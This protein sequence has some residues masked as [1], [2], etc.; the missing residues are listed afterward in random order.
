M[1]T[2]LG[3]DIGT[4]A[5]KAGLFADDGSLLA[6]A[7][8]EYRLLTPAPDRAEL[9]PERRRA[10]PLGGVDHAV[11]RGRRPAGASGAG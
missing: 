10:R 1:A 3:L 4:T 2:L 9:D 11:D 7:R 5:V 6:T 8:Q